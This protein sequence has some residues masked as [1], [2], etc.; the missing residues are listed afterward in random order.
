[1]VYKPEFNID[2]DI[3]GLVSDIPVSVGKI[4]DHR[5]PAIDPRLRKSNRVKSIQSSLAIEGNT[6]S[7]DKV[8]DIVAG[9]RVIGDPR[10]IQEVKGAIKAYDHIE[11]LNPYS[12]DDLLKVH[13]DMTEGLVDSPREFR[14]CGVGVYKGNV[15]IHI[16]PDFED[17]PVMI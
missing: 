15:P 17:V 11:D 2:N 6:L 1:M 4:P 7:I 3:L 12:I 9:K 14:D 5:I 10:E 8:T 16:A 13:A